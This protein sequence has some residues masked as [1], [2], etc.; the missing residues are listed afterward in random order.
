[1]IMLRQGC[2]GNRECPWNCNPDDSVHAR[3][4]FDRERQVMRPFALQIT[5]GNFRPFGRSS[6]TPLLAATRRRPQRRC[7]GWRDQQG[8]VS[9]SDIES[10]FCG[11]EHFVRF[12]MLLCDR[13]HVGFGMPICVASATSTGSRSALVMRLSR[14]RFDIERFLHDFA[15]HAG[16]LPNC[17]IISR[18]GISKQTTMPAPQKA[19]SCGSPHV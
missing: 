8:G 12:P 19:N 14:L 13:P 18:L 11:R 9:G 6:P 7:S 10:H 4:L 2:R 17:S 1:M 15:F 16:A 5:V 3:H